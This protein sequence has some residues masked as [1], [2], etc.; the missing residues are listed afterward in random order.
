MNNALRD[1]ILNFPIRDF[2]GQTF[3]ELLLNGYNSYHIELRKLLL[4]VGWY[5]CPAEADLYTL[6][7]KLN[8]LRQAQKAILRF[9]R[10]L[11]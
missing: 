9:E 10:K 7:E 11:I 1:K 4:S 5:N 6:E 8:H 2:K 3:D